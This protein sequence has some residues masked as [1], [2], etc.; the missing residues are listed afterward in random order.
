MCMYTYTDNHYIYIYIERERET[1]TH[2]LNFN[3]YY[4]LA[5]TPNTRRY[6]YANGAI[7]EGEYHQD[8][9]PSNYM[10]KMYNMMVNTE[11]IHCNSNLKYIH[12]FTLLDLSNVL[13]LPIGLE[14]RN[15]I[16]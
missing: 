16:F 9:T 15:N 8:P 6:T 4:I 1:Y 11:L 5:A 10:C 2:T 14:P 13:P 3:Y 7:F 12:L